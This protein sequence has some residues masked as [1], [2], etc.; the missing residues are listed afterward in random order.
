[1]QPGV[2]GRYVQ[3]GQ[4]LTIGELMKDSVH[5]PDPVEVQPR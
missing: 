4:N 1:M 5:L 2:L 3:H